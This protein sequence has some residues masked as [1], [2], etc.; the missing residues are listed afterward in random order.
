[1]HIRVLTKPGIHTGMKR[2]SI[3]KMRWIKE[4]VEEKNDDAKCDGK[5]RGINYFIL[6]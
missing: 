1:M 3:P 5:G 2:K 4:L 6:I